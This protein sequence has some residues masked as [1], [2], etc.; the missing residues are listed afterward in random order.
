MVNIGPGQYQVDRLVNG[1]I[2][3]TIETSKPPVP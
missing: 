1:K 2:V 3:T